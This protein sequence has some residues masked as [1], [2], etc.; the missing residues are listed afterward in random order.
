[1]AYT[2]VALAVL[3]TFT[4]RVIVVA[5]TWVALADRL[6]MLGVLNALATLIRVAL[7][8]RTKLA[9]LLTLVAR[10][11]VVLAWREKDTPFK[12]RPARTAVVLA[13]R[14]HK[15]ALTA[16]EALTRVPELVLVIV[17]VGGTMV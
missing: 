9:I 13:K 16:L 8:K 5:F 15:Y 7:A 2:T 12:A 6:K 11:A 1:M 14:F 17:R 10:T 4:W 3:V